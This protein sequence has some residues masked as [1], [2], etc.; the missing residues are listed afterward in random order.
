VLEST[1]LLEKSSQ[2]AGRLSTSAFKALIFPAQQ[3]IIAHASELA[4]AI[5]QRLLGRLQSATSAAAFLDGL[6]L[7]LR[8]LS[9]EEKGR[10]ASAEPDHPFELVTATPLSKMEVDEIRNVLREALGS[11]PRFEVRIDRELI[12]GLELH[13]PS[14]IVR[15]SWRADLE[16]IREELARAQQL[17]GS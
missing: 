15:N 3:A 16:R 9:S 10:F 1:Q 2:Y 17:S 14:T 6:R 8:A 12:A 4:M 13:S 5:A 7:E 11:E